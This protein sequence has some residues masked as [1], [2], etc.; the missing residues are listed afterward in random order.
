MLKFFR[1]IRQE[2]LTNNKFFKYLL[3]A[4]GEIILIVIGILIAFQLSTNKENQER[5]DLGYKYLTEMKN[6]VLYD[7]FNLDWRIKMLNKNIKNQEAALRTKS[8]QALEL[9]SLLMIMSQT[10]LDLTLSELTF[11]KMKNLGLTSLSD[12][13]KLNAKINTYYNSHLTYFK[14]I[15]SFLLKT[16]NEYSHYLNYEQEII[17]FQT[18]ETEFPAL[19]S[20]PQTVRDSINRIN[21]I[22]FITSVKGRNLILNDLSQKRV[23]SQTLNRILRQSVKFL[24]AIYAELELQ[25]PQLEPLI[26]LPT[27][28]DFKE[29]KVTKDILKTYTGKYVVKSND[30][31]EIIL[32]DERIYFELNSSEKFEIFAYEEEKFFAKDLF[33]QIL[34]NKEKGKVT[35]FYFSSKKKSYFKKLDQF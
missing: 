25:D 16:S 8:I 20:Q 14:T 27:E 7:V 6:E 5:S 29:I 21:Y 13:N 19:F 26:L 35:S 12:N 18:G 30:T 31:I 28:R 24:K 22:K 15:I 3:Y 2:M 34:F 9:D 4:F 1:K 33:A 10:S 32:E 23:A 17:D 11:N